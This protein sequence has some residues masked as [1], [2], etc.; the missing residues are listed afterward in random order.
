MINSSLNFYAIYVLFIEPVTAPTTKVVGFPLTIVKG[1]KDKMQDLN[2]I[3]LGYSPL[4]DSIYLY[5]HGKKP[6]IILDKRR[7]EEDVMSVFIEKMMYG[8]KKGSFMK[9]TLGDKIYEVSCKHTK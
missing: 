7:A 5:R 2:R 9:V 8:A 4:T 3:K 1:V 6:E